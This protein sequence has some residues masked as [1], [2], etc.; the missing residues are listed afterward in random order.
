MIQ[1]CSVRTSDPADPKNNRLKCE[2]LPE[3]WWCFPE[4]M[5]TVPRADGC[6][7]TDDDDSGDATLWM[8]KG[9]ER[10]VVYNKDGKLPDCGEHHEP[11]VQVHPTADQGDGRQGRVVLPCL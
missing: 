2:I 9:T 6:D 3:Y 4:Q 1:C 10:E 11:R 8:H 7:K 5:L